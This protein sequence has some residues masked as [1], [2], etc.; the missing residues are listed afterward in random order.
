MIDGV[1]VKKLVTNNDERGFFR[2][3]IRKT[4]DVFNTEFGQWSHSKM[5]AGVLKAWHIHQKQTDYWY[6]ANGLLR[7]ALCDRR[8]GSKTYGKIMEFLMGEKQDATVV[9]IPPG[10]A[11]GCRC[12][13]GPSDLIYATSSIYDPSDEGRI[14][15]DDKEIGYDW[16]KDG[17][18]K[19]TGA[20][21]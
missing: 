19:G 2:E 20:K 4:D 12:L 16:M 3:I 21:K 17:E 8:K 1:I 9:R 5:H 14:A 15:H 7:V 10:V 11:H 18:P 13:E 6:V